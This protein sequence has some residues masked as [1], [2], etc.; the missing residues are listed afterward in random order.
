MLAERDV[1]DVVEIEG[2]A[3]GQIEAAFAALV[4]AGEG[5]LLMAVELALDELRR[6]ERATDLD[7]GEALAVAEAMDHPRDQVLAHAGLAAE[8]DVGVGAGTDLDHVP[9]AAHDGAGA[10]DQLID[11]GGRQ[12]RGGGA[13]AA[14]DRFRRS[15]RA[16]SGKTSSLRNGLV[17]K[18]KAPSR[19]ASTATGMLP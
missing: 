18:S 13:P 19:I 10:D 5:A 17:T 4:G 1:V 8:E 3:F 6:E 14:A 15:M 16:K 9:D 2:A 12:R 7:V 11:V